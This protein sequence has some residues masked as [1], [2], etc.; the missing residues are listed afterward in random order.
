VR[1]WRRCSSGDGGG[2]GASVVRLRTP[3]LLLLLLMLRAIDMSTYLYLYIPDIMYC[4]VWWCVGC[5]L[6]H[7][8]FKRET[9]HPLGTSL[10]ILYCL[11]NAL[12]ETLLQ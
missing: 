4:A 12:I 10:Y 11:L 1:R 9:T 8:C 7:S 3:A 5:D 6:S 2:R